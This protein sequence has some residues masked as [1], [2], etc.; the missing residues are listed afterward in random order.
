MIQLV[1][2]KSTISVYYILKLIFFTKVIQPK[3]PEDSLTL[4]PNVVRRA[5]VVGGGLAGLSAALE[6]A[7]RGYQVINRSHSIFFIF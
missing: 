3:N 5:L 6:L 4:P 7:D 1:S 2:K